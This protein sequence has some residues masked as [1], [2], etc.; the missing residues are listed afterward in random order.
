M[1]G[2]DQAIQD[3]PR[4]SSS[5]RIIWIQDGSKDNVSIKY[6]T[7]YDLI[8]QS[9]GPSESLKLSAPSAE[10]NIAEVNDFLADANNELIV[11][12]SSDCK[13]LEFLGALS[14]YRGSLIVLFQ[15]PQCLEL[16]LNYSLNKLRFTTNLEPLENVSLKETL[17]TIVSDNPR[18]N[19][20]FSIGKRKTDFENQHTPTA[21][22]NLSRLLSLY[23]QK[24]VYQRSKYINHFSNKSVPT[25]IKND[26]ASYAAV[27]DWLKTY[28]KLFFSDFLLFAITS[29]S[30]TLAGYVCRSIF[31]LGMVIPTRVSSSLRKLSLPKSPRHDTILNKAWGWLVKNLQQPSC[32]KHFKNFESLFEIESDNLSIPQ[33]DRAHY[34]YQKAILELE[35][36]KTDKALQYVRAYKRNDS[37]TKGTYTSLAWHYFEPQWRFAQILE[38]REKDQELCD[39]TKQYYCNALA[40]CGQVDQA[41]SLLGGTVSTAILAEIALSSRKTGQFEASLKLFQLAHLKEPK[42]P[43]YKRELSTSLLLAG[44]PLDPSLFASLT[45][46]LAYETIWNT[47]SSYWKY[48]S[49]T[50]EP[51]HQNMLE[52]LHT[53]DSSEVSFEYY[54]VLITISISSGDLEKAEATLKEAHE[55]IP[56][57]EQPL[58]AI[59][60]MTLA[61]SSH[62]E[63]LKQ[64]AKLIQKVSELSTSAPELLTVAMLSSLAGLIDIAYNALHRAHC[65]NADFFKPRTMATYCS[66]TLYLVTCEQLGHL[67]LADTLDDFC[68]KNSV[69]YEYYRRQFPRPE[70]VNDASS[71]LP[72]FEL[73]LN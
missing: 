27:R 47:Y 73:I 37:E 39:Q 9:F 44:N 11:Y 41:L 51:N 22:V 15:E 30:E 8:E 58:S 23:D 52:L 24:Y 63:A 19:P 53:V 42:N 64:H 28:P 4:T 32:P 34:L 21:S 70:R 50:C 67:E 31:D 68:K 17:S 72:P 62:S 69:I 16:T 20:A 40:A 10:K 57:R 35:N 56:N 7:L 13:V 18:S 60:L 59:Y 55:N 2:T 5:K 33:E 25:W 54:R 12:G 26:G 71:T 46:K 66:L 38:W 45:P 3:T 43:R 1:S 36:G 29:R 48:P 61:L 49:K 14:P 6:H 65:A